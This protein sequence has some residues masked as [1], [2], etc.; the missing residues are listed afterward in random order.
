MENPHVNQNQSRLLIN[1]GYN[2]NNKVQ[3]HQIN[4]NLIIPELKRYHCSGTKNSTLT[5]SSSF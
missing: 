5:V 4:F 3:K 2:N 1:Y